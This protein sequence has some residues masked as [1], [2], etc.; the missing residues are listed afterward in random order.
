MRVMD[1]LSE[2]IKAEIKL[3]VKEA[4]ED[5]LAEKSLGKPQVPQ[6]ALVFNR[7][8]ASKRLGV[9][10]TT[11]DKLRAEIGY[12]KYPGVAKIMWS[13]E[14]LQEYVRKSERKV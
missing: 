12:V 11:F 6:G 13:E 14:A 1:L 2:Q 4:V 8:E 7:K 9:A 3:I 5:V 10:P